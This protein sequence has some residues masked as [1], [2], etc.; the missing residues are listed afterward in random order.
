MHDDLHLAFAQNGVAARNEARGLV[1]EFR[2][3]LFI[4]MHAS[5]SLARARRRFVRPAIDDSFIHHARTH[6]GSNS[7]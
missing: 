2:L 7:F 1:V 6:D 5:R 4:S 3:I